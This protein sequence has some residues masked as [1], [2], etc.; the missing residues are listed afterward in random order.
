ME[1]FALIVAGGTGTRMGSQIAKQYLPIG[2]KPILMHTLNNFYQTDP[3][4]ALT[5]VIPEIDFAY[6][7]I[8]CDTYRFSIPHQLVAGGNSRF[9]SVKN[10]LD[11]LPEYGI[12]AIHDGVRPFV[13]QDVIRNSFEVAEQKGSAVAVIPLKD[14]I[15]MVK[16]N[17]ASVFQDRQSFR[18]VQTPQTFQLDRI[19][20]AFKVD[21]L[22]VFTD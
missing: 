6:W 10:G 5:L 19:K 1:K 3:S 7:R 18:L 15:R 17:G 12:V 8:L 20:K 22:A 14:S 13:S 21:E 16:S 2:E 4:I 11:T 9:K